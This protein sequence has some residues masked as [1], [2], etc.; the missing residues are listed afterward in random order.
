[1]NIDT[2]VFDKK[3]ILLENKNITTLTRTTHYLIGIRTE[4]ISEQYVIFV[5][6]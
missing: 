5:V 1:M 2:N 3:L 6:I 4:I